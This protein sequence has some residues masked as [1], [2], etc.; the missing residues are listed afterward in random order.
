MKNRVIWKMFALTIVT[1][2]IYRLYWFVKTRGEMMLK[3]S[4]VKILS[5]A[6][7]IMPLVLVVL[8]FI[9]FFAATVNL[10]SRPSHCNT[11][12][13]TTPGQYYS[14]SSPPKEC[15]ADPPVWPILLLYASFFLVWPLVIIWLWSYSRGVEIITGGKTSFAM[16]LLIL[17]LVPDGIDILI[18]QDSFNKLSAPAKA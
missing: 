9:T 13:K 8:A 1:L 3:N 6:L 12:Y 18:I 14:I 4:S 16:S 11:N 5:P 15:Q 10:Y 7:L 2:G 17:L